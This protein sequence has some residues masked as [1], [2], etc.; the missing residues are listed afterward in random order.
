VIHDRYFDR[1]PNELASDLRHERDCAFLADRRAGYHDPVG[2]DPFA[3]DPAYD[4]ER[5]S[6]VSDDDSEDA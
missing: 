3:Y 5:D 2:Y 6:D 1:E 4:L